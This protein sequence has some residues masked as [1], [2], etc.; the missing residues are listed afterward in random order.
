MFY[1][2][3]LLQTPTAVH[4]KIIPSTPSLPNGLLAT[5]VTDTNCC[6]QYNF[7]FYAQS[8]KCS[9]SHNCYQQKLIYTIKFSFLRPVS[10]MFHQPQLLQTQTA[11]HNTIFP[12]TSSLPNGLFC[13]NCYKHKLLYTIQFSFLRPVS[14][15]V[16]KPQLLQTQTAVHNKIFLSTPSL[17]NVH[18]TTTVTNT[19]CCTQYNFPFYVQSPKWSISHN[20]YKHKMLYT[21]QFSFLRPVS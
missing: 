7:T 11:V 5:T 3:Q 20:C 9:I 15:M 13:H 21:I 10:Q 16:Y 6:T 1:Q 12:S 18:L 2:P 19:N 14:Q 4:N 8:H 17:P